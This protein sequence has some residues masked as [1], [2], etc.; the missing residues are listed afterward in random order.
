MRK[1]PDSSVEK[2]YDRVAWLYDWLEFPLEKMGSKK[3]REKL[4]GGLEEDRILEI[5]VGTGRNFDYYR[6]E[7]L[8]TGI[9]ISGRMLV[10]ARKKAAVLGRSFTLLK[11]DV[12]HLEFPDHSFDG[13]VSTYVFCS[14][15]DPIKGLQEARRVL[16]PGGKAYFLEHVRPGGL[17]GRVFDLLSP[18][19]VGVTGVNINRDTV[20]NMRR[21]GFHVLAEE[22]L[23][24]DIFKLIVAQAG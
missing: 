16:K 18:L 7:N 11:M 21:A 10:R 15:S 22:N 19:A 5:G 13:V 23:F 20:G 4:F 2:R 9:D 8:V 3:W 12:Q 17:L 6:K 24:S 1:S 14:V